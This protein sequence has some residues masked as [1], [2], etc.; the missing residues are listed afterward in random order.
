[1]NSIPDEEKSNYEV[2][3]DVLSNFVI[4]HSSDP[5]HKPRKRAKG[6]KPRKRAK[7]RKQAVAAEDSTDENPPAANNAE[8]LIDFVEYLAQELFPSLPTP[9][10]TL[11]Y[12]AFQSDPTPFEPY[13]L[14][15]TNSTLEATL[16]PH[17]PPSVLDSLTAYSLAEPTDGSLKSSADLANLFNHLLTSYIGILTAPPPQYASTRTSA[18]ELCDRSWIPL[19]YH[20]LIPR[21][22]HSK[23]I[24]RGWAAGE[25][26]LNKVA[27]LCGACHR[28]VHR[29]ASNEDLARDW[30]SVEKL[31]HRE[32]VQ[33]FTAWVRNIRWKSR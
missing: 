11:S 14:P 26:E 8:E 18:C 27:W 24:K 21:S 1:M 9:L 22:T 12:A 23:A 17:L 20:H 31:Q 32:D 33:E 4:A 2:F 28:F 3:R 10:R 30:S 6:R 13:A 19:T 15:L 16:L 5:I 25:W 7:G 29:C